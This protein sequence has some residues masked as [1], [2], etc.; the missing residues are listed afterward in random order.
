[1]ALKVLVVGSGAREHAIAWKLAQSPR[2]RELLVAPGNAGTAQ[3]GVNIPIDA[4]DIDGLLDFAR[5]NR[6]DF[7]V[8][9]PEAPLA[10]GIVDKFFAAGLAV[11]GP[12][13]CS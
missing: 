8:I 13:I 7:T 3:V 9:G 5:E 6:V 12:T 10:A 11:F 4:E 2:L 1:M